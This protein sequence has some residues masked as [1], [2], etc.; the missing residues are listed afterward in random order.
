M[1]RLSSKSRKSLSAKDFA[2]PAKREFPLTDASHD[3]D[4]IRMAA[5]SERKGN[6]TRA[7]QA[8][9]DHEARKKLHE[10]PKGR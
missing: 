5:Y 7:E 3:R 6:I 2:L 1:G 4:A 9:V 10:R 8:Q